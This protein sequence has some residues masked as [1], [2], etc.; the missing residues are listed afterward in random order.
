MAGETVPYVICLREAGDQQE[1]GSEP[2]AAGT[3]GA[4]AQQEQQQQEGG[5]PAPPSAVKGVKAATGGSSS[6]G[7]LAERA[8]H[9]DELRTD[10]SLVIDAEYYLGQQVLPVIVRL[11]AP[12]EVSWCLVAAWQIVIRA[13]SCPVGIPCGA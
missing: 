3:A 10:S 9:P 12:I 4:D 6:S 13:Q 8:Y 1:K 7:S 2:S 5:S 11:C